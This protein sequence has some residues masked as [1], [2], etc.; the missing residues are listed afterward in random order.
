MGEAVEGM[1]EVAGTLMQA[2]GAIIAG[3]DANKAAKFEAIQLER[4]ANAELAKGSHR[5]AE[6][7]RQKRL[8]LSRARAV[9]AASGGGRA[10]EAEGLIEEEG[11]MIAM[12]ELFDAEDARRGRLDQAKAKRYDGAMA[13]SAGF[14]RAGTHL[15]SGAA[16]MYKKY[17]PKKDDDYNAGAGEWFR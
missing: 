12:T 7:Q 10:F 16:S 8:K 4:A 2:G 3:Q 1:V 9:G 14:M 15:F 6:A 11:E 13:R 17:A 5:V